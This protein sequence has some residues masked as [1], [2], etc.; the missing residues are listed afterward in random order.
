MEQKTLFKVRD[1]RQKAQYKVDDAYLNGYARVCKPIATVV[2]NS[3]CRHAEFN[4]QK[5]FPSQE[6]M[7][8]QHSISVKAVRRGI[9]KLIEYNIIMVERKRKNG[10]FINYIYTL[11]DKSEW[12]KITSG[13]KRP[14]VEPGDKIA[15]WQNTTMVKVP[16]KDNKV[17]KDN[18]ELYKDNK[19]IGNKV[20][21]IRNYFINQCKLLKNFEPEMSFG[22]EGKLLKEKLKRYSTD[23]LKDLIDA[24]FDS[25]VGDDLGFSLS[26][27]LSSHTINL[28]KAGK[29]NK[30]KH[31]YYDDM[32][33][34]ERGGK[35]FCI[36]N[37]GSSFLEFAGEESDIVWK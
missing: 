26:I 17:L 27:C 4:S 3:L 7:A 8:Y 13:Q 31:P 19:G 21:L 29:L 36:P 20:A 12:K 24:F 28:W 10:K 18:K 16:T 34:I 35:K 22:K 5:A 9:K 37:D 25:K 30:K 33:V 11:L 23:Q 6:L 15:T 14:M 1:L 2:Y 32:R